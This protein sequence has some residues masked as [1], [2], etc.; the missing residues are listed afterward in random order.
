L[1]LYIFFKKKRELE[2]KVKDQLNHM[3]KAV[4]GD[5]RHGEHVSYNMRRSCDN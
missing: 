3:I 4:A 1:S 5:I 2:K